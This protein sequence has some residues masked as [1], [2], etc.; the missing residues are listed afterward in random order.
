MWGKGIHVVG[1]KSIS[2]GDNTV[3]GDN[4]WINITNRISTDIQVSIGNNC[5]V[6]RRTYINSGASVYLGN[7]VMTGIDCKFISSD[8][9]FNDPFIPYIKSGNT[10]SNSLTIGDNVWIGAGVTIVGDVNIGRGSIIG[11]SSL[12]TKNIPPF[13][14]AVGNP[15]KVIKRFDFGSNRWLRIDAYKPDVMDKLIPSEDDYLEKLS[16]YSV[17]QPLHAISSKFGDLL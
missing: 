14:I 13:S 9:V 11:A 5:L 6:G 12:V 7:Y 8:H 1:W 4:C 3:I 17:E 10:S 15:C 2:I 16:K